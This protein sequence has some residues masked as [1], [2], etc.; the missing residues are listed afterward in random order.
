MLEFAGS[1]KPYARVYEYDLGEPLPEEHN[2]YAAVTCFGSL[3]PGYA[4][5]RCMDEFIR[6]TKPG[7]YIIFN[8]RAETYP[9][10]ELKEKVDGLTNAGAWKLVDLSPIFRSYYFIE[11]DVKSQVYV[12]QVA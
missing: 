8:T 5:P 11:P 7:G 2:K 3:G 4:P 1:P 9:K 12:F 10:Q 6:I